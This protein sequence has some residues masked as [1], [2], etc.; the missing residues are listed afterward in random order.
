MTKQ[1]AYLAALDCGVVLL[2][3]YIH[4]LVC[5]PSKNLALPVYEDFSCPTMLFALPYTAISHDMP[6]KRELSTID[7]LPW[8]ILC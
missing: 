4:A 8:V 6:T 1:L 2:I 7:A 3:I 5:D